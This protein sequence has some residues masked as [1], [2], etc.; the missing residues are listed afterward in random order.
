MAIF[1]EKYIQ[2]FLFNKKNKNINTKQYHHLNK[3]EI[4]KTITIA[5]KE[6]GKFPKLKK[7]TQWLN[8]NKSRYDEDDEPSLLAEYYKNS[9]NSSLVVADGDAW[10]G[11]SALR[12][13]TEEFWNDQSNFCDSVNNVLK[14][15][16]ILAKF[17][18]TGNADWDGIEFAIK[19]LKEK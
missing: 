19:S 10:D 1:N 13:N 5:K 16:N 11:Y 8:L 4:Y 9:G 15:E 14:E 18:P 17:Y 2:E 12:S 7:A 3:N 6:I